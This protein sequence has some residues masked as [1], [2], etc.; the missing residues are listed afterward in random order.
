MFKTNFLGTIRFGGA[1]K[2][3]GALL[4]NGYGPAWKVHNGCCY[5][6][7]LC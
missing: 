7:I 1:L 6:T 4:L 2:I 5:H 3:W